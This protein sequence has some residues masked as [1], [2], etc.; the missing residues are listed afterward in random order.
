MAGIDKW[1]AA[2]P[3]LV[4]LTCQWSRQAERLPA[5]RNCENTEYVDTGASGAE[6]GYSPKDRQYNTLKADI[7]IWR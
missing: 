5:P 1:H 2:R 7:Y 4:A 3:D 6:A